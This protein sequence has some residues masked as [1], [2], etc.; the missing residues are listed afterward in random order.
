MRVCAAK[1]CS[2]LFYSIKEQL[3]AAQTRI[4]LGDV[5]TAVGAHEPD[6]AEREFNRLKLLVARRWKA[7]G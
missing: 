3:F 6:L 7:F 1:S 2:A 5:E 4:S